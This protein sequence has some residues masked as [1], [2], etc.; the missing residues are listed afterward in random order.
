MERP[1]ELQTRRLT[2]YV[3]SKVEV[4]QEGVVAYGYFVV[5]TLQVQGLQFGH[6][7]HY[8][9]PEEEPMK[10]R[11]PRW[12]FPDTAPEDIT[13]R[14]VTQALVTMFATCPFD[15]VP[16]APLEVP[17]HNIPPSKHKAL[18]VKMERERKGLPEKTQ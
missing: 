17:W 14:Q 3:V 1:A 8:L 4:T 5:V 18:R 9:T 16:P 10:W 11:L 7:L 15:I 6:D 12:L 13:A 2:S